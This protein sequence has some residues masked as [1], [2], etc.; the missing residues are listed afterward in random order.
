MELSLPEVSND[1]FAKEAITTRLHSVN[2]N[3]GHSEKV[4]ANNEMTIDM[5]LKLD[6]SRKKPNRKERLNFDG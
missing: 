1:L 3:K 6:S 2:S 4:I 5:M